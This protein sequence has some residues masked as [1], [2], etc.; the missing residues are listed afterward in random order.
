MEIY[1]LLYRKWVQTG[2]HWIAEDGVAD[3][4]L[5]NLYND[6]KRTELVINI[7]VWLYVVNTIYSY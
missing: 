7:Q 5:R 1:V 4:E 6:F 3:G 2:I